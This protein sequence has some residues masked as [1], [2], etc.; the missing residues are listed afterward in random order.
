MTVD[1]R[2]IAAIGSAAAMM[3]GL[4]GAGARKAWRW[5]DGRERWYQERE[6]ILRRREYLTEAEM[7]RLGDTNDEYTRER[8]K[9]DEEWR[10]IIKRGPM[11]V[12]AFFV[13]FLFVV[14]ILPW[15]GD[16]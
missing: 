2:A 1:E 8:R 9:L 15:R 16:T 13:G 4:A 5:F 7:H 12:L 10:E 6:D 3:L 11:M 14:G